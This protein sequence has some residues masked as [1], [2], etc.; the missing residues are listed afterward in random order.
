MCEST[1]GHGQLVEKIYYVFM[2]LMVFVHKEIILGAQKA[3]QQYIAF[4]FAA[5]LLCDSFVDF[6]VF[7]GVCVCIHI[8]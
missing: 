6:F 1:W 4:C 8:Y 5:V 7:L 2:I 3:T